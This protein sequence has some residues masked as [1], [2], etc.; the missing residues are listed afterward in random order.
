MLEVP[1][2]IML[3]AVDVVMLVLDGNTCPSVFVV[4]IVLVVAVTIT[5]WLWM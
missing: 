5:R 1:A 3:V 2:T 4:I